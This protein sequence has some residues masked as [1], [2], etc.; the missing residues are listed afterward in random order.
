M[1]SSW[2]RFSI[3][4]SQTS[5]YSR[6]HDLNCCCCFLSLQTRTLLNKFCIQFRARTIVPTVKY[7][8][9]CCMLQ[10]DQTASS[11]GES[12]PVHTCFRSL[13]TELSGNNSCLRN[14]TFSVY[15]S[16]GTPEFC[17]FCL[18]SSDRLTLEVTSPPVASTCA[19]QPA[20]PNK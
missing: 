2:P 9:K 11:C 8:C 12:A 14:A 1:S 15:V 17:L 18:M 16:T 3:T 10:C 13:K 20:L 6:Y 7:L 5:Y 19:W 4:F